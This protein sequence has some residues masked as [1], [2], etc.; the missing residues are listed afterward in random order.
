MRESGDPALLKHYRERQARVL[1]D[2]TNIGLPAILSG[3]GRLREGT[4]PT[5]ALDVIWS[6]FSPDLYIELVF[7]R[8]WTPSRYEE[9]L[10]AAIINVI[11]RPANGSSR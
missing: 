5:E 3:S 1:I 8:G 7:Q 11:L 10:S 9:W 4:S 6:M 2:M